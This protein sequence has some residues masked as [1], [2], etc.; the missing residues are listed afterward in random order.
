MTIYPRVTNSMSNFTQNVIEILRI[1][2]GNY[3]V[4]LD[5]DNFGKQNRINRRLL[6]A[7]A[8][9]T[10]TPGPVGPAGAI[11]PQGPAGISTGIVGPIGPAGVAGPSGATGPAGPQTGALFGGFGPPFDSTGSNGDFYI[12]ISSLILYGPRLVSW[13]TSPMTHLSD[14]DIFTTTDYPDLPQQYNDSNALSLIS[15]QDT[16]QRFDDSGLQSLIASQYAPQIYNDNDVRS[17]IE[18]IPTFKDL[19]NDLNDIQAQIN[20]LDIQTNSFLQLQGTATSTQ[21]PS[22]VAYTDKT[23]AFSL[24]QTIVG[25]LASGST[26][27]LLESGD[28]SIPAT[29]CTQMK[30]CYNGTGTFPHFIRT[31]H[32]TTTTNS[33]I[34]FFTCDGTSAGVFPTNAQIGLSVNGGIVIV[35]GVTISGTDKLQV[36][37]GV[38][39]TGKTNTY[40]NIATIGNGI[41]AE[42]VTI[43]TTGLTANV[44]STLL[45]TVPATAALFYRVNAMAVCTTA[46]SVSSTL[47]NI[48]VLFTD[49][50]SNT[51]VT[52]DVTP[53]LGV[54]GQGQNGSAGTAT[55]VVGT[56]ASGVVVINAKPST[57]I[58]YLTTSYASTIAGMTYSIRIILEAL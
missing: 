37:G 33:A 31:R 52:L 26:A 13:F 45:Y 58:N 18:S 19:T 1:P 40:N 28:Q 21:L 34:D 25:T 5:A 11:G 8:G 20:S 16:I 48:Q 44:A 49:T 17:L 24:Q 35:G 47:P 6:D 46:A 39:Q 42:Y 53:V 3:N 29:N 9:T 22:D 38:L 32:N 23:N 7:I 30:L 51:S 10:G 55:N 14:E 4:I 54:P 2:S 41:P 43:H 56:M 12:N 27:L 57:S 50:D 36:N 15:S